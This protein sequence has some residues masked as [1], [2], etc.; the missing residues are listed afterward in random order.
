[1]NY[2][3][4]YLKLVRRNSIDEI[5]EK[6]HIFPTSI[7]GP[8]D[9]IVTLSTREHF[10]AH[11]LLYMICKKRYGENDHRTHKML[12][13][14]RMMMYGFD[15]RQR[16]TV[17]S[18]WYVKFR[19]HNRNRIL[20]DM[21]PAKR[22]EARKKISES[23]T[24]MPRD[25]M[26]GKAYFGASEDV[27]KEGIEKMRIKKTGMKVNYPKNRKSRAYSE[28]TGKKISES[29]MKTKDRFISMSQEEFETWIS[30]QNLYR[31]D[32]RMNQ[33]VTRVLM[34]RNIPIEMYYN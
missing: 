12:H 17:S 1:M 30:K 9:R 3:K 15:R 27:A 16:I 23:K 21:N 29:R 11:K 5:T 24:G 14:A 7:F 4:H 8:N 10:L 25:D 20:G 2:L 22:S 31:K 13:A 18:F 33:N 26:K 6:H 28:E 19:E 34:W 32:K